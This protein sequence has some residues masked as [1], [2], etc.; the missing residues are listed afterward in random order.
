MTVASSSTPTPSVRDPRRRQSM[1]LLYSS[2]P[3]AP[4]IERVAP[5]AFATCPMPEPHRERSLA[6]RA[7]AA[8]LSPFRRRPAEEFQ[9]RH[10]ARSTPALPHP[11]K[12]EDALDTWHSW[13]SELSIASKLVDE[14][15]LSPSSAGGR[16]VRRSLSGT[17]VRRARTP[18]VV[19]PHLAIEAILGKRGLGASQASLR[20]TAPAPPQISLDFDWGPSASELPSDALCTTLD[21]PE[22]P[23]P[24]ASTSPFARPHSMLT[25][26]ANASVLTLTKSKPRLRRLGSRRFSRTAK[27]PP[28]VP[29]PLPRI[30]LELIEDGFAVDF[31]VIAEDRSSEFLAL[32]GCTR[33]LRAATARLSG[34][35]GPGESE[36]SELGSPSGP[37]PP[38]S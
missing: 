34:I 23:I 6:A 32:H 30:E 24:P 15:H 27:S 28:A 37:P 1:P 10:I 36:H 29:I 38:L 8:I 16:R 18:S 26:S 12:R 4:D 25:S 33:R 19:A 9:T 35:G 2:T 3:S 17:L 5:F 11:H 22:P 31:A 21:E 20:S 13:G 7:F 14:T